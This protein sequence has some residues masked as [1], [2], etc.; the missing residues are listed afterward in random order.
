MKRKSDIVPT[1]S[2]S[3]PFI[4]LPKRN[5]VDRIVSYFDPVQGMKRW[6]SRMATEGVTNQLFRSYDTNG[7]IAPGNPR[8]AM[9][10][11]WPRAKSP[12]QDVLTTQ[13]AAR[14]A[15]RDLYMNTAIGSGALRRIRTN[16]VGAG[17]TLQSRIDR[18]YLGMSDDA[19]DD[20]EYNTEREFN[21][22]AESI[23]CDAARS[24]NFKELQGLALLSTLMNGDAFVILPFLNIRNS[25]NPYRLRI[26]LVEGD[27]CRNPMNQPDTT[28]V[29]AGVE[30]DDNGAPMAYHFMRPRKEFGHFSYDFGTWT[31]VLA[32]GAKSGRRNVLHLM[33]KERIGQ[34]RGMPLLATVV[35]P[36]KQI[37]RLT[38]AELMAS[39]I[40][41]FFTVFVKTTSGE[42]GMMEQFTEE[43]SVL[44]KSGDADSMGENATNRDDNLYELGS[45]LIN[46]L[47]EDQDI[48]IADP[49][50]PNDNYDAFF[51]SIVKQIGASIEMPYEQLMMIYQSSYSASRAALLEAWKFYRMRRNWLATKFCQPIY[52]E[53]LAEAVSIGRVS[54][55][56]FFDDPMMR[57]AWSGTLW[58][59][60]GQ[61][62]IDPVKETKAAMMRIQG[63][64][65]TYEDEYL[66]ITGGDWEK[67]IIRLA[68][69]NR[70]LAENELGSGFEAANDKSG[71]DGEKTE[72][73]KEQT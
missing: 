23:D 19:A 57:K 20:W 4:S 22:W 56:G 14:A 40:A 62:Q 29:A 65:S 46:E 30:L 51:T 49:K 7:Y 26:K 27:L 64:L 50:R 2:Q 73:E 38:E 67:N 36:I 42:S 68:R 53:W 1:S 24:M 70:K 72:D 34:R 43:E 13:P 41:S 31:K 44:D 17:L 58:A 54:A 48:S 45:G 60:Q 35:E 15:C 66:S 9:R 63:K 6:Q 25:Q 11:W 71:D 28:R 8:R 21:L 69:Q 3:T 12:D 16:V 61:G 47:A 37:Q 18:E 33:D 5:I 32:F 55:P 39:V 10:G 52:E 59:G